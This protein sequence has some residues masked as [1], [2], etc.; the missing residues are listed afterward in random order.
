MDKISIMMLS[1]ILLLFC[2]L[3][4]GC[5]HDT[6]TEKIEFYNGEIV[7]TVGNPNHVAKSDFILINFYKNSTYIIDLSY[8]IGGTFNDGERMNE[9]FDIVVPFIPY[10]YRIE[11]DIIRN[12]KIDIKEV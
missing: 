5:I 3:L 7:V 6:Q 10:S 8:N 12:V 9:R 11:R 2:A 4:T 1:M